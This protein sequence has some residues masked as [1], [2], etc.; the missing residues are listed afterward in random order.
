MAIIGLSASLV[1]R[2]S[3]PENAP[4]F[5]ELPAAGDPLREAAEAAFVSGYAVAMGLVTAAAL[6][7]AVAAWVTIPP[8]AVEA[9]A[10]T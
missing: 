8:K 4:P 5:G 6:L 9:A 10:S 2:A 7:A 3:A 1:Y